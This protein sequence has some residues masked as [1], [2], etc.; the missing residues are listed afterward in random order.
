MAPAAA[1]PR[2]PV[3]RAKNAG[4]S[5]RLRVRVLGPL[6]IDGAAGFQPRRA[7]TDELIAYLVLHPGGAQRDELV[8]A[9]WPGS[10]PFLGR[11]RLW[12]STSE[13]RR[14]LRQG[15]VRERDRYQLDRAYVWV[16]ADE[17]ERLHAEVRQQGDDLA[18]AEYLEGILALFR[19]EPLAGSDY[20]WAQG[21]IRRLRAIFVDAARRVARLRLDR[22]DVT[23]ALAACEGALRVD[24]L[25]EPL[26][27]LAMEAEHRLG[28][29]TAVVARY[30]SLR[31]VLADKI[32]LEPERETRALFRALMAQS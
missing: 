12:Q 6:Q 10:D 13:A 22:G 31:A 26:W 4:T 17:L 19:G 8:E 18:V 9:L 15:V 21:E 30:D 1:T 5:A 14:F 11:Q 27:R 24:D 23:G 25:S 2:R 28:L 7:S 32:G 16:D 3:S 20:R 29:R